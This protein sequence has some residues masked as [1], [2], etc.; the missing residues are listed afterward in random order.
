MRDRTLKVISLLMAFI[1]ILSAPES[2]LHLYA[3]SFEE[4]GCSSV[5]RVFTG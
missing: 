5:L 3:E 1:L 2:A 4:V